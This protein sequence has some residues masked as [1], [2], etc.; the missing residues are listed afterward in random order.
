MS[1]ADQAALHALHVTAETTEETAGMTAGTA[2]TTEETAG[3]TAG[4][5]G[6]TEETVIDI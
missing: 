3:M 5:A 6:T 1:G 4:I 2:E